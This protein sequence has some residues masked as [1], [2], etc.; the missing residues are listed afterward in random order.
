MNLADH[1]RVYSSEYGIKQPAPD[2]PTCEPFQA[3]ENPLLL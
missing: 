1:K 3:L 2:I